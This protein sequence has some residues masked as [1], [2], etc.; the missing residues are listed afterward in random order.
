LAVLWFNREIVNTELNPAKPPQ[1]SGPKPKP[2]A[3]FN[4]DAHL[5]DYDD[6]KDKRF[7]QGTQSCLIC[8]ESGKTATR[9]V[10]FFNEFRKTM[11]KKPSA[12][13]CIPCH[14]SE[15]QKNIGGAVTLESAKCSVCHALQTIK[16]RAAQGVTLPPPSHFSKPQTPMAETLSKANIPPTPSPAPTPA[17]TPPP[18]QPETTAPEPTPAPKPTTTAPPPPKPTKTTSPAPDPKPPKPRA[19]EPTPTETTPPTGAVPPAPAPPP[20]PPKPAPAPEPA[21][22]TAPA[23]AAAAP[24]PSGNRKPEPTGIVR[25]GDTKESTEWG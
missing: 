23:P 1:K 8:H 19:T 12:P 11:T 13:S 6:S 4:H 25:L 10:D 17:P 3:P 16:A 18:K 5:K 24:A 2:P 20:D 14:Q 15:M 21:P 9:R 7:G 22:T